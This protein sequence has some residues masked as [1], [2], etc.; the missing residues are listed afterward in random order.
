MEL[1]FVDYLASIPKTEEGI[2]KTLKCPLL[3]LQLVVQILNTEGDG[4]D[5]LVY[6]DLRLKFMLVLWL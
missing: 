5:T 1:R 2:I 3:Y 6:H 4:G